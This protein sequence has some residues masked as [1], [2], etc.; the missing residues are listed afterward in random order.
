[1]TGQLNLGSDIFKIA[2]DERDGL[3]PAQTAGNAAE[4][5]KAGCA[6]DSDS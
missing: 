1:M 2:N 6:N 5:R 3:V 4:R